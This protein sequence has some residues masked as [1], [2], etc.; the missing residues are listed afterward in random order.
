[1][2]NRSLELFVLLFQLLL[3]TFDFFAHFQ[4]FGALQETVNHAVD[5][6]AQL[7]K[8]FAVADINLCLDVSVLNC[9][10]IPI[11]L[12]NLTDHRQVHGACNRPNQNHG[13]Q[14]QPGQQQNLTGCDRLVKIRG[15]RCPYN[16]IFTDFF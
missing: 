13:N 2:L 15:G 16:I 7:Q 5:V 9:P 11:D 3:L 12:F 10:E 4:F 14:Q 6:S 8:F 1:M